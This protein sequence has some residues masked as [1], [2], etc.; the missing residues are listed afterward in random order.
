MISAGSTKPIRPLASTASAHAT[1]AATSQPSNTRGGSSSA[2]ANAS[3]AAVIRP[4]TSMSWFAYC[5]PMKKNGQ[6]A[7]TPSVMA[8]ARA[9]CQRRSAT[10]RLAPSSQAPSID[11]KR[12]VNALLPKS[13]IAAMSSQ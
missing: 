3:T 1:Q 13:C 12:A 5:A 8:A 4:A 10:Y 2:R 11:A 7:S 9:P 6:V